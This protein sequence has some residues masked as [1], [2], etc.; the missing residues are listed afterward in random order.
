MSNAPDSS[1][2]S[3]RI[4]SVRIA[5]YYAPRHFLLLSKTP[6]SFGKRRETHLV[7]RLN[8]VRSFLL[9]FSIFILYSFH[10]ER[11]SE[12]TALSF[13]RLQGEGATYMVCYILCHYESEACAW[14]KLIELYE[15]LEDGFCLVWRYAA[16]G[17]TA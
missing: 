7:K 11:E 3:V 15:A 4:P 12:D 10:R 9:L 6:S 17:V 13:D 8:S 14:Y 1:S 16:A 5:T 2:S